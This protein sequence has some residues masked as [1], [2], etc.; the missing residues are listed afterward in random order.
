MT[1]ICA[2]CLNK[3]D[4]FVKSHIVPKSF[5]E[6]EKLLGVYEKQ[7]DKR[8]QNGLYAEF[9]CSRCE[10]KFG[11]LDSF[12]AEI[13]KQNKY[14]EYVDGKGAG[15]VFFIRD[16]YK[17]KDSLHKF[18]LSILWRAVASGR[19]EFRGIDL[20]ADTE[21]IR[22]SLFGANEFD[23][24]LLDA[25][26]IW[27]CEYRGSAEDK[28]DAAFVVIKVLEEGAYKNSFGAFRTYNFGFPYG[29]LKIRF[30]GEIPKQCFRMGGTL[31]STNLSLEVPDL[32]CSQ[33]P[34][35]QSYLNIF[36]KI[37]VNNAA[38]KNNIQR[39]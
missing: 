12:A 24:R 38:N 37:V 18:A 1:K 5:Y 10:A 11:S 9:L 39:N 23:T 25:T 19:E 35:P 22:L 33:T 16:L 32:F 36:S 14:R 29:E 20:G 13:F 21:R 7:H 15:K 31:W 6:G 2:L 8:Y 34:Q 26:G 17:K 27:F 3:T 4:K 30:G 28:I